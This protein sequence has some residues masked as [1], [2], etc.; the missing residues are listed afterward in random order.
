[1]LLASGRERGNINSVQLIERR[2][3]GSPAINASL[4]HEIAAAAIRDVFGAAAAASPFESQ[5]Q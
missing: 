3:R 1:M 4:H 5:Q 2:R